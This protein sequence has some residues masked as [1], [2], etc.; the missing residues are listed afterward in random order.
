M[1]CLKQ[2]KQILLNKGLRQ[3]YTI[4]ILIIKV[5]DTIRFVIGLLHIAVNMQMKFRG[6]NV[7]GL[8][9]RQTKLSKRC[10]FY[11][12]GKTEVIFSL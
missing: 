10:F 4:L 9:I 7:Y 12:N 3:T 5:K 8:S 6:G 11:K 2:Q 1:T